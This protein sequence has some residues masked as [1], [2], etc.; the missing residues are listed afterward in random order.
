[1]KVTHIPTNVEGEG[2][3]SDR[4]KELVTTAGPK[5]TGQG[6]AKSLGMTE[7]TQ[8]LKKT[9]A[10]QPGSSLGMTDFPDAVPAREMV[11]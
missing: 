8:Q 5:A 4:R 3:A 11:G 10:G 2:Q 9:G 7:Q 1:M 6:T